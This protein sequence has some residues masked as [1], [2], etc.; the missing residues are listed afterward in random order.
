ML[1]Q[2]SQTIIFT[3]DSITDAGR[4]RSSLT[5]LGDGYVARVVGRLRERYA[6]HQRYINTGVSGDTTRH[7]LER[8]T[9]DV[10]AHRP[11]WVSIAVGVN[12]VW[13]SFGVG[14]AADAV[15]IEEFEA[16]YR[17]LIRLSSPARL[18]LVE[19]FVIETNRE[20]AFRTEVARYARVVEGLAR[21]HTA[22]FV[23][24]QSAFDRMSTVPGNA[25]SPDRVHPNAAGTTLMTSEYLAAIGFEVFEDDD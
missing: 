4:D 3:G 21:A 1:F 16:N 13:R 20:D 22:V 18:I 8:W 9:P 17:E 14:D 2:A 24:F 7:L 5:S 12:D 11:D 6:Q 15:S 19:P 23:P 25:W 10:M